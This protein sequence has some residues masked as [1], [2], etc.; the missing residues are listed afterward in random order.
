MRRVNRTQDVLRVA[1]GR[2]REQH[3]GRLAERAHL[4][5]EDVRERVVVGDRGQS[6]AIGR[7]RERRQAGA[8]ELEA[9]QQLA[10]EVL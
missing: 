6:R 5:R 8:L 1:R 3:V 4:L 9:I 10:R 7:E 2:D